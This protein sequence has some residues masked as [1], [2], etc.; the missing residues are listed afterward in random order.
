VSAALAK[1]EAARAIAAMNRAAGFVYRYTHAWR[2]DSALDPLRS[3][4]DFRLLMMDVAFP[5]EP[6]A[7]AH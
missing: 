3:R 1:D 2:T 5:S 7:V 4:D 6:F